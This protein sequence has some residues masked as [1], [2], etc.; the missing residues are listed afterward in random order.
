[1]RNKKLANKQ[2]LADQA[3]YV[4][5]EALS[6]M[7]SAIDAED[8]SLR[9]LNTIL[10][11]CSKVYREVMNDIAKEM[12][13]EASEKESSKEEVFGNTIN[14]LLEKVSKPVND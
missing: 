4:A 3:L 5:G 8:C 11:T 13:A 12:E 7:R 1:M 6:V 10:A 9:D 14:A 2:D